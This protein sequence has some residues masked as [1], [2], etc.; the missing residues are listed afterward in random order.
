[1]RNSD[2]FFD[3]ADDIFD[4]D[5]G[6]DYQ[7][8]TEDSDEDTPTEPTEEPQ[9]PDSEDNSE[10]EDE[11]EDG[12]EDGAEGEE[13]PD[14]DSDDGKEGEDGDGKTDSGET[15][16]L[17]VNKEEKQ[18]S[19]DEVITRAQKGMDYDRVKEQ[20]AKHQQTISDLQSKLDGFS[21][22]Q[23]VLDILDNIAQKSGSTMEQL[24]ESLYVNFR[25]SAGIS[26][27]TAR[28][29]LKNAKLEKE[30]NSYKAQKTQQQEKESDAET[31]AKR[32]LEEF[33]RE[34]PDV[35][36][37]E[38]MVDKLLPDIQNGMSL[39]AA[40]RKYEKAKDAER[41]A[42]L[43]RKVANQAQAKKNKAKAVGSK[44]DSGAGSSPD[45]ADIFERELFK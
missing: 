32:D 27:D 34:Y 4:V 18:V 5:F 17:K 19:R 14:S 6:D 31:R 29:E 21:S 12:A 45:L 11:A 39:S 40:Y 43:E 25:K 20:N 13:Q 33:A 22:Q 2:E 15:F 3:S 16:T 36:L 30:L 37:S 44:R 9:Q 41:I 38:E 10:D 26:E 1:M 8:D 7:T 35:T 42:D 23:S 28:E 24:A